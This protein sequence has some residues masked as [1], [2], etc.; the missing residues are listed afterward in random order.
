[1]LDKIKTAT[2]A[3]FTTYNPYQNGI[4]GTDLV[5]AAKTMREVR[6]ALEH[7]QD[8]ATDVAR[9]QFQ[10]VMYET[11][12]IAEILREREQPDELL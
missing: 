5:F 7:D 10:A 4:Y 1:M 9:R 6:E 3:M 8:F 12:R 2:E 11:R